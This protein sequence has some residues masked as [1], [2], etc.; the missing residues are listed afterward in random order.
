MED[1]Q[2]ALDPAVEAIIARLGRSPGAQAK[3]REKR[4][5]TL[6]ELLEAQHSRFVERVRERERKEQG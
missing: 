2:D 3:L 4:L 1:Q 5:A 6:G